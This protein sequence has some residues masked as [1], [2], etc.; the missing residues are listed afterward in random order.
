[1]SQ[2]YGQSSSSSDRTLLICVPRLRWIPEQSMHTMTPRLTLHQTGSVVGTKNEVH[3]DE[4][5]TRERGYLLGVLQSA[6]NSF[7]G[8]LRIA[9]RVSSSA[10]RSLDDVCP[11]LWSLA[12]FCCLS[13]CIPCND[14]RIW[15]SIAATHSVRSA[16]VS[17]SKRHSLLSNETMV[18]CVS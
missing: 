17:A 11:V 16:A 3:Q 15:C 5:E 1:M 4:V 18:K 13:L 6:Q 14:E 2:T 9:R 10:I 7:P 12:S 8:T